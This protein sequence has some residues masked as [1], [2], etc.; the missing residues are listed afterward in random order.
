MFVLV[1]LLV[2]VVAVVDV[3]LSLGCEGKSE[4]RRVHDVPRWRQAIVASF[5]LRLF[6]TPDSD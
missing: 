6:A 1:C 4:D 2:L 3:F 5:P